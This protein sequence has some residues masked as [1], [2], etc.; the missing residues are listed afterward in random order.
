MNSDEGQVSGMK[1]IDSHVHLGRW[2]KQVAYDRIIEPLRSYELDSYERVITFL[3]KH[4]IDRI[5]LV[6][7]Y[8]PN[9]IETFAANLRVVECATLARGKIVPGIWVDPSPNVTHFLLDAIELASD[10]GIRVLKTSPDAW[11]DQYSPDPSTWDRLFQ[12]NVETIL[13]YARNK[14]AVFQIHTGSGKSNMQAIEKFL[15]F[16]GPGVTFHL[17]HM[18][19]CVSGHFYLVPRLE[20]W[21]SN[22]LDIVCD[23][24]LARGFAVRWILR[25]AEIKHE[26][27]DRILFASD[28]P[29]GVFESEFNKVWRCVDS[30]ALIAS[31]VLWDNANRIYPVWGSA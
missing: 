18:G 30:Q 25:E 13:E 22:G 12:R 4:G 20:E 7:I 27:A 29:W 6:P 5:V 9:A 26:L 19:S 28:E 3:D 23:T 15:K 11:A 10:K 16:T 2:G 21:L 8:L 1:I 31:K 24:S 17:V 14:Q